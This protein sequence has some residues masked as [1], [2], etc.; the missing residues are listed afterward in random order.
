MTPSTRPHERRHFKRFSMTTR[1]CELA[2]I[3]ARGAKG[4]REKCIL[5]DLSYSGLR[6]QGL[7]PHSKGDVHEFLLSIASPLKRAGFLRGRVCWVCPTDSQWYDFGVEL[8][9]ESKGLLGPD[10]E[11]PSMPNESK[12]SPVAGVRIPDSPV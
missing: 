6:F 11:W 9:E 1:D 3:R 8:L 7:G 10:E 5:V 4:E 12:G 2:I